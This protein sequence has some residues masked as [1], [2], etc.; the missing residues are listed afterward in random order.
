MLDFSTKRREVPKLP[1]PNIRL[2][3]NFKK[4]YDREYVCLGVQDTTSGL[5][6]VCV[7]NEYG[8]LVSFNPKPHH[9]DYAVPAN[10]YLLQN[11]L[12]A[13]RLGVR[14]GDVSSI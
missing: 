9:N 7:I 4:G 12:H 14:T 8:N 2:K 5:Q 10:F 11:L 13:H 3:T 1:R 6:D